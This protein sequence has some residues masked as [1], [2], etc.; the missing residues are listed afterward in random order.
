MLKLT[1]FG[2]RE[3][4]PHQVTLWGIEA[5][6]MQGIIFNL[7]QEGTFHTFICDQGHT[8][9]LSFQAQPEKVNRNAA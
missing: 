2:C 3:H 9:R 6:L 5:A 4:N 8:H 1:D 7:P